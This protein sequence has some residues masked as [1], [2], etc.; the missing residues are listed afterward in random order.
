MQVGWRRG[1]I[2]SQQA[3]GRPGRSPAAVEA[4]LVALADRVAR[5]LRRAHRVARPVVLRLRF[6]DFTRG[7]PLHPGGGHGLHGTVLA[8]ARSLLGRVAALT[9]ERGLTLLGLAVANLDD[10]RAV[11]LALPLGGGADR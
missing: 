4:A 9:D 3:L 10:D 11:Q 2:G 5:R 6:A 1:S 8:V 7:H